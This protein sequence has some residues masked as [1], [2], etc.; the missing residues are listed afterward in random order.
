VRT[1][2][3]VWVAG[4]LVVVV[5]AGVVAWR[6]LSPRSDFE[7]AVRDLPASTLR[8]TYTDWAG[9]RRQVGGEQLGVTSSRGKVDAFLNRA[10]DRDLTSGSAIDESTY[11]LQ[12]RFAFSPLGAKWE[13]F[14][15]GRRGQVDLVRLDDG[16]DTDAIEQRLRRLGYKPPPGGAGSGGTWAGSS[17]LVAQ[18]D[19]DLTPVQQN[20]VVLPDQKLVLMSDNTSYVTAA[21]K[22]V[23]GD[24]KSLA[25]VEGISD[26]TD[27]AKEPVAAVMWSSTFACEDLSMG[28]ADAGD[29]Q[30]G[31]DLIAKAGKVSPLDGLVMA[32]QADRTMRVGIH[33]ETSEQ[34][35]SNLQSRVDL[36]SGDAPGQG[37]SFADRFTV[38]SGTASGSDVVLTLRLKP[39]QS[40]LSD[41]STGPVL[42]AT[43]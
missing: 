21:A 38:T 6:L 33:F 16:A 29:Q 22:V 37:G 39:G 42:F 8:T 3:V 34:A 13:A 32:Q 23:A 20:F 11:A 1:R 15:Q 4:A 41:L 12:K 19:P 9:I 31:D 2:R 36:A 7:R 35:S 27:I 17:D 24:A 28:D 5:L 26:L 14:G 10:Y 43:C 25:D 40:V 30:V 18:I